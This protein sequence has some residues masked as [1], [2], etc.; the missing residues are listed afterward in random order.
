LRYIWFI[1]YVTFH[2]AVIPKFIFYIAN[3]GADG[4]IYLRKRM[5]TLQQLLD[6]DGAIGTA[7]SL[8]IMDMG[9]NHTNMGLV[10]HALVPPAS[11][12]TA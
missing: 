3:G 6:P 4:M 10:G 1:L 9:P 11:R 12:F 5:M 2:Y 7:V 8:S